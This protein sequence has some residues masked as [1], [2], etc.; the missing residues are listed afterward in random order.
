MS[1][2]IDGG[3]ILWMSSPSGNKFDTAPAITALGEQNCD[4]SPSM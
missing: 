2:T 3:E 1:L 4:D